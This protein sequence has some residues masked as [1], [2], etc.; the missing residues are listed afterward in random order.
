MKWMLYLFLFVSVASSLF[1]KKMTISFWHIL[2]YH[3]K[4]VIEDMVEEYNDTKSNVVVKADF[5]G[6][7]E[8]AQVKLL[9]SAISKSMPD[10]A[11]VPIEFLQTYID[12]GII[13]PVDDEIP[14]EL[15]NDIRQVMWDL[16][17]FEEGIYGIPF[18]VFTDIFY[19]NENAFAEAGLD[20]NSAPDSWEDMIALGKKLTSDRDGDGEPDVYALT[21]YLDGMYGIAPLLWSQ[22]GDF[23]TDNDSRI[24]L[25]SAEMKQS[26]MMV[27]DLFFKHKIM[28]RTWTGWENAQA[29]LTG[30]L[31]MGW[32]ISAGLP[33]SEQNLPW[34]VRIAHMPRMGGSRYA[35]LSGTALVNFSRSRKRRRAATD[36]VQWLVKKENDVRF[37]KESGFVPLR[38]SSLN[39]LELKAFVRDNPNYN[40]ALEALDYARPLPHHREFF[41][42]NQE[43]SDMLERI[44]LTEADPIEELE[45][46][47]KKINEMISQD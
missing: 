8:D 28:A 37:L 10:V 36:F 33:F 23:F 27:H 47:E 32:F 12:N 22:G 29:F 46:T 34:P 44:I 7:F 45:Q 35:L 15:K 2:G 43:I 42:I 21:F 40:V 13:A 17:T 26:I 9:T 30:N 39:S 25:T 14:E 1:A 20:P 5:Q 41:K 31:A 3:A 18:C 4:P 11:Q 16:V 24:D 19:Y 38:S 6:F